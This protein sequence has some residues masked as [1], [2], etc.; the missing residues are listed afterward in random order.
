MKSQ[1]LPVLSLLALMS[2]GCSQK[3]STTV[4]SFLGAIR[5]GDRATAIQCVT[6]DSRPDDVSEDR[7]RP[8]EGFSYQILSEVVEEERAVV[9]TELTDRDGSRVQ[10]PFVLLREEGLWKIDATSTAVEVIAQHT[11]AAAALLARLGEGFIKAAP[12]LRQAIEEVGVG[13]GRA[14]EEV[15]KGFEK[16]L[17]SVARGLDRIRE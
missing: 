17:E 8:V 13:L 1:V 2:T 6:A 16:G 10:V 15:G 7:V 5:N 9:L 4:D 3:P 14:L 11:A 12:E